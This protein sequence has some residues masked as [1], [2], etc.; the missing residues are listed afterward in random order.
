VCH[1]LDIKTR[2]RRTIDSPIYALSPDATWAV[3]TDFRRIQDTRPG[4]G[5]AGIVDPARDVG[6]PDDAGVWRVDLRS[7]ESRLLFSIRQI[8]ALPYQN[9]APKSDAKHWFN[10]L[11]VSPDGSRFVFLHRWRS[12]SDTRHTTRMITADPD[13]S[14]LYVL[15]PDGMTSHFQWRDPRHLLAFAFHPSHGN[16]FYLFEDRNDRVEVVGPGVMTVDGHCSYLPGGRWVLNDTYP[17]KERNQNPYLFDTPRKVRHPLGHFHSPREY[18]GEWRCDT[19]PRSSPD[20]LSV[21]IDS[22][23]GGQGRQLYLIDVRGIVGDLNKSD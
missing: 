6:A 12:P 5:Y 8:A 4:Y 14:N 17:D 23:H 22:P 21:V 1:I 13:G 19:H 3:T 18:T 10:H 16:A 2:E 9:S 7:G 11:L 20:G 15:N